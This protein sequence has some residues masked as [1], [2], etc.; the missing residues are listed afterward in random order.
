VK[1]RA[2]LAYAYRCSPVDLRHLDMAEA[3]AMLWVLEQ[4]HPG[5]MD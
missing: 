2:A 3:G 4:V 5:G 1:L